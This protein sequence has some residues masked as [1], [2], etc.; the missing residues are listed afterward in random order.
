MP[1][2]TFV[3]YTD[4]ILSRSMEFK[5]TESA[6]CVSLNAVVGENLKLSAR[7]NGTI[8]MCGP[9]VYS[10]HPPPPGVSR[11]EESQD[12]K[13]L[14]DYAGRFLTPSHSGDIQRGRA[15]IETRDCCLPTMSVV[16]P[17]LLDWGNGY[18]DESG[19]QSGTVFLCCGHTDYGLTL[20]P[21][22]GEFMSRLV[23]GEEIPESD[24]APF[25]N[26]YDG[27]QLPRHENES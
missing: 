3:T 13:K 24:A 4:W 27:Y 6:A 5:I 9:S 26:L 16:A 21:A 12:V 23:R 14:I 20:G 10:R 19:K 18:S 25:R 2:N 15:F 11:Q 8:Y 1:V 22:S 17:D 7:G